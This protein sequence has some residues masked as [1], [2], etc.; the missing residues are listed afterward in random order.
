MRWAFTR[1]SETVKQPILFY[2][3]VWFSTARGLHTL[4]GRGKSPFHPCYRC[5]VS[6]WVFDLRKN[7]GWCTGE[8]VPF[9]WSTIYRANLSTFNGLLQLVPSGISPFLVFFWPS[10]RRYS[11][12]YFALRLFFGVWV[13]RFF[14]GCN[15]SQVLC[16]VL[17]KS[18]NETAYLRSMKSPGVGITAFFVCP[19]VGNKPASER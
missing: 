19:T 8:K 4:I 6:A 11:I 18:L 14:C 10:M 17:N 5:F 9:L 15:V 7:T 2:A 16:I 12:E 1:S 3:P 13:S